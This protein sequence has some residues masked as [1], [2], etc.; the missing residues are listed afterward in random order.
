M[1]SPRLQGC[2]ICNNGT[3]NLT[4]T[5]FNYWHELLAKGMDNPDGGTSDQTGKSHKGGL[6]KLVASFKPATSQALDSLWDSVKSAPVYDRAAKVD[7]LEA[8]W[9]DV[10]KSK[11]VA[12][13]SLRELFENYRTTFPRIT[14]ALNRA[15]VK[16]LLGSPK[17]HAPALMGSLL[18]HI[19]SF[20]SFQNKFYGT[21][22]MTC[23]RAGPPRMISTM[24]LWSSSPRNQV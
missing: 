7:L 4:N 20:Q 2:F 17:N 6:S 9:G 3:C 13:E 10:F 16:E 1:K 8:H 12:E 5:F 21:V 23:W 24:Q 22:R 11:P 15:Y 19:L 18:L 14:W